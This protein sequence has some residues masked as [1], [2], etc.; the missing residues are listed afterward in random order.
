VASGTVR[1]IIAAVGCFG[2]AA[3]SSSS[4]SR[5]HAATASSTTQQATVTG[6]TAPRATATPNPTAAPS[7]TTSCVGL[8]ICTQPPPDTEGNPACYYRDGWAADPSG[9]GINV[10]YFRESSKAA[11]GEQVTADVRMKDGTTA[12]QIAAIDPGQSSDQ[13]Q[14]P[15]IDKSAVQK[16]LL[17]TSAGRC[18]VIG[19]DGS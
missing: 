10:Y 16:V 4:P 7:T 3:C 18:F 19:P 6:T 2:L 9:I 1:I 13:I 11:N 12:S 14:F 8:S 17:T 5:P 15:G